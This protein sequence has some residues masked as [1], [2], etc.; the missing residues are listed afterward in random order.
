MVSCP[1]IIDRGGFKRVSALRAGRNLRK[2]APHISAGTVTRFGELLSS[3]LRDDDPMLRTAYLRMLVS[4]VVVSNDAIVISG[5]KAALENGIADGVPRPEGTVPIF[6]RKWCA[7]QS[8]ANQSPCK[9]P[10]N[11]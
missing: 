11:G 8:R 2:I 3:K 5:P 6:D 7:R 10:A 1:A 4:N 9:F